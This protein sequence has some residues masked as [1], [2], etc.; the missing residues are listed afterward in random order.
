MRLHLLFLLAI[1]ASCV[2]NKKGAVQSTDST[3]YVF[4]LHNKFAE[5][6]DL[7][8]AHPQYGKV[9]YSKIIEAFKKDKCIVISEKRKP[10]TDVKKYA[11]K[12]VT[13]I[14]SLLSLGIEA[15]R[16][17]VIGTSKGGYIAQY[18]ST[19]ARNPDINY[20][21]IGCFQNDDIENYPDIQFCGN[22]LTI[23]EQSDPF[24]VSAIRRKNSSKLKIN[25]F[26]EIELITNLNHGF[27]YQANSKWLEPCLMWVNRNYSLT[28]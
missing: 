1:V 11:K 19:Y 3:N 15:N 23:Y 12:V 6:N 10:N 26:K 16:I 25:Q 8:T 2:P 4:F 5:E 9:E 21:F 22:I 27:L 7:N 14:D 20:V 18:V 24:G 28:K 17:S 13:K